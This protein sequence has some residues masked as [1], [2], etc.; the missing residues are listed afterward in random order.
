M[1][2]SWGCSL[3]HRGHSRLAASLR[4]RFFYAVV[5]AD[6]SVLLPW[7]GLPPRDVSFLILELCR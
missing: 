1:W 3:R 4:L 7:L 5:F 6:P 2:M